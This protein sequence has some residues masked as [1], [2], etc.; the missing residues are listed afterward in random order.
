MFYDANGY[1]YFMELNTYW[2]TAEDV[3][4]KLREFELFSARL[5]I[6][7]NVRQHTMMRMLAR[8]L[9]IANVVKITPGDLRGFL[10]RSWISQKMRPT[11]S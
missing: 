2:Y 11:S 5:G 1:A 7:L 4:P 3:V 8:I 10:E 6:P 9:Q